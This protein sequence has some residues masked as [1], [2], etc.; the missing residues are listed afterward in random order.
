MP[1]L[2]IREKQK[3]QLDS[4]V[5]LLITKAELMLLHKH[6]YSVQYAKLVLTT[7]SHI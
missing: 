6:L 5:S 2:W 3:L 4:C 7:Q 1:N